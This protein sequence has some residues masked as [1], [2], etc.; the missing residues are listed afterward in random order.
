MSVNFNAAFEAIMRHKRAKEA[1][2][3]RNKSGRPTRSVRQVLDGLSPLA[4]DIGGVT[5]RPKTNSKARG[6]GGRSKL[7]LRVRRY[8]G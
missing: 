7:G 5:A 2:L 6:I 3:K 4:H 1:G 8:G